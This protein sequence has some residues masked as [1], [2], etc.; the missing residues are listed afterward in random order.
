MTRPTTEVLLLDIKDG[1]AK[2]VFFHFRKIVLQ[3]K[4]DK[5]VE[6]G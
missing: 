4:K 1:R 5:P 2:P 6:T 3:G